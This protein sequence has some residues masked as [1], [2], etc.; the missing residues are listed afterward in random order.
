MH[1]TKKE[2]SMSDGE[3]GE[4]ARQSME[5]LAALGRIYGAQNMIPVSSV[6]VAGVS[7]KTIGDAGLEY[8]RDLAAKGAKVRV[9]TFLNPAGMDRGQWKEMRVPENFAKKQLEV[10]GAYSSMGIE[11]TCTCTP[12]F[13]GVRPSKGEHIA[14]S[15]SSAV[16]FANSVLGARTNR[17]G[18]PSALA[19][20]ICGVTPNYGLHLDENRISN[21]V[22][23]VEAELKTSSD[24]GA[25]GYAVGEMAKGRHVAFTRVKSASEDHLKALGA[26]MAA[27]GSAALFYMKGITPEYNVSDSAERITFSAKE[28]ALTKGKMG[29]NEKPQLVAIGCPHASIDEIAEVAA[30]VNGKKLSTDLWVCTARQTKEKAD[31]LGYT[32]AIEAAGGRVISDT[33]MVVCPLEEMGYKVTASN[34]GKAAK[35]LSSMQKQKVVFGDVKD[36][37]F[38]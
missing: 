3:A 9:K 36:I 30:L 22:V 20:A 5:I 31:R 25:M 8:L 12:Y 32:R 28:L 1:L 4:A 2:Q 29:T 23:E 35:Y 33:C 15:E 37:I 18:G 7:Y 19:A 17:E 27:S 21:F 26:A 16:A 34:S 6:Q 10:L 11:A 13:I 14:W 24:F 38:R